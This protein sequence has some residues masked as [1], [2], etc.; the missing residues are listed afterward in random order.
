[1]T[2]PMTDSLEPLL[3]LSIARRRILILVP[4][5]D[6]EVVGCAAA[7]RR[8]RAQGAKLFA[9]YLTTGVPRRAA[10]WPWDRAQHG[11]RIARRRAEARRAAA[12]LRITPVGFA[13]WPSRELKAHLGS[14]RAFIAERCAE[15]APDM[16]WTPA[17]EGGHQDHDVTNF[18]AST[19]A[20]DVPV[21]EFA[22]Y[23]ALTG[24]GARA[25]PAAIGAEQTLRL[26]AVE[27]A[28]KAA[29]LRVYRSE[30]ANLARLRRRGNLSREV[31]RPLAPYDYGLPAHPGR[32]FYQRFQWLPFAHPRID[33]TP[34]AAVSAAIDRFRSR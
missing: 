24:G 4:H 32:L 15:I 29:L 18:L 11:T 23:N 16:L 22:E 21:V 1:M 27:A 13:N 8:A 20:D 19:F 14:A 25:F 3:P 6:D 10:A 30:R 31:L 28:R 34:P 17:Y 26:S 9:I 5:P 33:F 12:L 2:A 7:I